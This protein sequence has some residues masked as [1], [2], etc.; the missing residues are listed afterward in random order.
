MHLINT[1]NDLQHNFSYRNITFYLTASV[2]SPRFC[3]NT[4][5]MNKC[6]EKQALK[7]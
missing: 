4:Q 7:Y 1:N 2:V 3:Y 6:G 5:C